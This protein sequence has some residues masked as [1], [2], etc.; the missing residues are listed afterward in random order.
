M[1]DLA[2]SFP[3]T[4]EEVEV[5]KP[6]RRYTALAMRVLVVAT[7]RIEGTWSAC[8]DAVDGQ[9]HDYEMDAV[10]RWGSKLHEPV[11]RLLFPELDGVP[12][13]G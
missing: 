10:L 6:Y 13:D 5:W 7:T 4:P 8:V 3:K 2:D 12:Y 11:A 1:T 9:N